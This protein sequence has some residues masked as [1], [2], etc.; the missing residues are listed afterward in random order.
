MP[1]LV[2]GDDVR[3]PRPITAGYSRHGLSQRVKIAN[4]FSLRATCMVQ[5]SSLVNTYNNLPILLTTCKYPVK[6]LTDGGIKCKQQFTCIYLIRKSNWFG[7]FQL[8]MVP[9]R[10]SQSIVVHQQF[11]YIAPILPIIFYALSR[12]SSL[13]LDW[14][15]EIHCMRHV[16]NFYPALVFYSGMAVCFNSSLRGLI[17]SLQCRHIILNDCMMREQAFFWIWQ[18]GETWLK[19]NKASSVEAHD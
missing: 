16:C 5:T 17:I 1:I 7:F 9:C 4:L 12:L 14:Q 15:K 18:R 11:Y 2:K 8:Q 10:C 6:K 13:P 3:R 19:K